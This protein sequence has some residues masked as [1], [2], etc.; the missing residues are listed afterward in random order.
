MKSLGT[1]LV[2][3]LIHQLTQIPYLEVQADLQTSGHDSNLKCRSD[4]TKWKIRGNIRSIRGFN[5]VS[6]Q[7]IETTA[8]AYVWSETYDRAMSSKS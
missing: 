5:R 8:N 3:E 7:L 1:G 4:V 6:V 2:E